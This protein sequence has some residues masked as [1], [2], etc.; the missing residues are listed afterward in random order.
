MNRKLSIAF[1]MFLVVS[2][3]PLA[4]FAERPVVANAHK[5]SPR[6]KITVE[7][8]LAAA[9]AR[10]TAVKP[11]RVAKKVKKNKQAN[12]AEKKLK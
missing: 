6:K 4:V 1:S 3:S 9:E 8:K 11:D 2:L 5:E 10:K 7:Q 12:D